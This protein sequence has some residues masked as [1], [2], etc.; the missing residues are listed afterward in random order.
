MGHKG[1]QVLVLNKVYFSLFMVVMLITA[2][3]TM[4]SGNLLFNIIY[5]GLTAITIILELFGG[6][7]I[8]SIADAIFITIQILYLVYLHVSKNVGINL[9]LIYWLLAPTILLCLLNLLVKN[10]HAIHSNNQ[11]TPAEMIKPGI[12]HEQTNLRTKEAFIQDA[13]VFIETSHR[14]IIPTSIVAIKIN[15]LAHLRSIM[16]EAQLNGLLNM[17][18][19]SLNLTTREYDISYLLNDGD[20]TTWALLLYTDLEGA[21]T[22]ATRIEENFKIK[23]NES[24][25]FKDTVISLKTGAVAW[26]SNKMKTP[27]DFMNAAMNEV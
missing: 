19:D 27:Y 4:T 20:D 10:A 14:F 22:V 18:T 23:L 21:Y 11:E 13:G 16:G 8:G 15:S 24:T 5:L 1:K 3:I 17:V 9:I 6:L 26:D 2:I 12:F 25:I 7:I